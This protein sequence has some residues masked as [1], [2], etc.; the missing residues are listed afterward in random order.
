MR[1]TSIEERRAHIAAW[2][3]SGQSKKAYCELQ[4]LSYGTFI[5]WLKK[6]EV[7][8]SDFI[9]LSAPLG[10]AHLIIELPDGVFVHY[11]GGLSVALFQSLS[12]V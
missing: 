1:R 4:G 2:Q 7:V 10:G 3:D 8:S 12:H 11:S 5:S 9:G 6:E